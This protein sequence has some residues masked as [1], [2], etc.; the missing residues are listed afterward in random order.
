MLDAFTSDAIPIHLLTLEAFTTYFNHLKPDGAIVVH[1]SNR[2]LNLLRVLVGAARQSR[3][4]MLGI[5]WNSSS[6]TWWC[7]TSEWIILSHNASFM[8]SPAVLSH[9][10]GLPGG[11]ADKPIFWTDDYASLFSILEY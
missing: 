5:A 7:S 6:T 1:I 8:R 10:A 9:G 3:L 4:M 11:F 2:H